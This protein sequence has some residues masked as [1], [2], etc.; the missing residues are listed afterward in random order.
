MLP[1]NHWV[2]E[3]IK[4]EIIKSLKTNTNDN[5]VLQKLRNTAELTLG[6][7]FINIQYNSASEKQ[8]NSN[9]QCNLTSGGIR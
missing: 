4:E 9:K 1:R 6:D 5:T 7:D 8:K 3:E 2:N